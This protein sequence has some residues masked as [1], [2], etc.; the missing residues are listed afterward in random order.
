MAHGSWALLIFLFFLKLV[1][2]LNLGAQFGYSLN[3]QFGA[4]LGSL[5]TILLSFPKK[6]LE[7]KRDDPRE[8]SI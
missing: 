3:I 6:R 8:P 5:Y 2:A 7:L 1:G 4:L